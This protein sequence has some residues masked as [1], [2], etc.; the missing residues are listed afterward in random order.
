M[1]QNVLDR[2]WVCQIAVAGGCDGGRQCDVRHLEGS[3]DSQNAGPSQVFLTPTGGGLGA[4]R[5]WGRSVGAEN[6]CSDR[7]LSQCLS[8]YERSARRAASQKR[9]CPGG[10]L[11]LG[12]RA[13][14]RARVGEGGDSAYG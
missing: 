8:A 4:A 12:V 1:I 10:K 11:H 2:L 3:R 7:I 13:V 14:E 6:S 5:R 9:T